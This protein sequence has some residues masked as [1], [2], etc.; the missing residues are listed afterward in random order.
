MAYEA[1]TLA[2]AATEP[3]LL[4]PQEDAMARKRSTQKGRV[5]PKAGRWTLRYAIRDG[6][7]PKGWR[8][9]REFLPIGI[10]RGQAEQMRVERMET[11]NQLNNSLL[12]QPVMTLAHFVSS[13]W[14]DYL[15]QRN[16]RESTRQSY[17]SMLR[18]LVLPNFGS[19]PIDQITPMR[20]SSLFKAAREKGY[21][22]KYQLNLYALLKVLFDVAREFDLLRTSPLRAKLHRPVHERT[23]KP[24]YTPEQ[25]RELSRHVPPEHQLL[26]FTA[27]V[28][29]LRL[30][31]LLALQWGDLDG[32]TLRVRHSLWRGRLGPPKT[33]A[34]EARL[35]LPSVLADLLA[36]QRDGSGWD[37]D[38]HFIFCRSDGRPLDPDH[39]RREVLYP[40]LEKAA[41]PRRS[42]E[43]GFHAFRHAAG[44]ILYEI[45]RD[46][47]LVKKFL[48]H[49]RISTTSDVYVHH[50]GAVA[51][52][53]AEAMA[54]VFLGASEAEG[55]Q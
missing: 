31:E 40:A 12:A 24:A 35:A 28:L 51:A 17:D 48:R 46:V 29:G 47:E 13:L 37:A 36:K 19:K 16:V 42:R 8:E 25:L 2:P 7:H 11:I 6:Q 4:L 52:E 30:G 32:Q 18:N 1:P 53:G 50:S 3:R 27:S 10:T 38:E 5:E 33:R 54:S 34:S 22:P 15:A 44:S 39:L 26:I 55:I 45:T 43:N 9:R 41:I 49:S 21:S 14:R 23:E 20:L